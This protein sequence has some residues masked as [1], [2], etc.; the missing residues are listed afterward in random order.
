MIFEI[1]T[2]AL[3]EDNCPILLYTQFASLCSKTPTCQRI[4][5]RNHNLLLITA[6][7]IFDFDKSMFS[8]H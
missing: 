2:I 8:L 1:P 5:L 4:H 6:L 7:G 3:Q